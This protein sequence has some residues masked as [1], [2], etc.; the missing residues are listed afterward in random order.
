MANEQTTSLNSE[1]FTALLGDAQF[2]AYENSV[3]R[4]VV[5]A[6]DY[7]QNAGKVLQIPV[8][9]SISASDL[10]EGT[11]ATAANTNTTSASLTLAEIG[12]YFQVT[13]MLRDSAQRDVIGDLGFQAGRAIA[14]KM[15]TGVFA[16]FSTFD[17][18]KSNVNAEV[19]VDD[20]LQGVATLRSRKITGPFYCILHPGV[21]YQIKKELA[22]VGSTSIPALSNAGNTVLSQFYVGQLAG[23]VIIES[24]LVP[25][26]G[27]N[28]TNGI[29]TPQAL[30]HAMRG[31]VRMETQRQA[32]ARATDIMMTA[33]QGSAILNQ[34]FG[35][36]LT[37]NKAI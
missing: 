30:A 11:A 27:N 26:A 31:G 24:S 7:P 21:A 17:E 16:N 36:K 35:V 20:I 8:Y 14:E 6:L 22:S 3:A 2:A 29:F 37:G 25:T 5:T 32:A 34:T 9:A 10:S 12:T 1:L 13:D 28:A 4:Q 33:V 18:I 23:C 19:T 15:D